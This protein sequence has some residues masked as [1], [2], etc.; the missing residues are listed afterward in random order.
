[1]TADSN[2]DVESIKSFAEDEIVGF[3]KKLTDT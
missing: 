3:E 2:H 1:M